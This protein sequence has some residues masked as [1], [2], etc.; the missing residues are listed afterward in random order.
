[1][2]N[3]FHNDFVKEMYAR[4]IAKRPKSE[5]LF[6]EAQQFLP[7]GDTRHITF[8]KPF[9]PFMERGEGFRL[10]DVDGY[11]YIDFMNNMNSLIHGHA[12]PKVVEA[13]IEQVKRGS[14][15]GFPAESQYKL[16]EEICNRLPSAERV[17]FSNSGTE[18]TLTAI[19]LAR[20]I[21]KRYKVV[22][23]EG[24]YHG[25]YDLA[26]IS[27][28]PPLEKTGRVERP[29]SVPEDDSVPPN[30][31][32]DCVIIPFNNSEVAERVISEQHDS[33]AAVIVEPLLN[34]AGLILPEIGFL[35]TLRE[36]CSKYKVLLIFDEVMSFRLS[37]GGA[38]EIFGVVPDLTALGK[39]IGGGYPVGAVA[40]REEFMDHFSPLRPKY[41][42]HSGTFNGNPVTM[43]AGLVTLQEL[44]FSEMNRINQ[45]GEKVRADLR[46]ITEE[47][48]LRCQVTGTGSVGQIHFTNREIR[49]WRSASTARMDMRAILHILLLEKGILVGQ[50][51]FFNI[52]TPMREEEINEM[53]AA[54][55]A[56]L[57][58]MKPYIEETAPELISR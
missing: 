28:N 30:V 31:L 40:G 36:A 37:I 25:T 5:K 20:A 19:R 53:T 14:I 10:Y 27:I 15:F 13:V 56:C 24:G 38:Q 46:K 55:K 58:E 32:T 42:S 22:K 4:Y 50:R 2:D 16:A 48:G 51:C 33:L 47:V 52:S 34:S 29:N 8:F 54:M 35:R 39:I 1:M 7:G 6:R 26:E 44:T 3:K 49:D 41:L 43:V 9:S 12:H 45:F 21:R 11:H 23:I 18:A 57:F 17:R